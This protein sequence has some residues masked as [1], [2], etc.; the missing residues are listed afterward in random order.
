MQRNGRPV[1]TFQQHVAVPLDLVRKFL[2]DVREGKSSSQHQPFVLQG[3]GPYRISRSGSR[4]TVHF[5]DGHFEFI[6]IDPTQHRIYLQGQWW[7]R[8]AYTLAADGEGT[9]LTLDVHNIAEQFHFVAALMLLPQKRKHAVAFASFCK[10]LEQIL[11]VGA[12]V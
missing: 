11:G 6:T 1:W 8:G 10:R 5:D 4:Y 7:Y 2:F 12:T 9:L 3:K